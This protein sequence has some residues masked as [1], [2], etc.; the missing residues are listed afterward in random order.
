MGTLRTTAAKQK[1]FI[2]CAKSTGVSEEQI[3]EWYNDPATRSFLNAM[4]E[5]LSNK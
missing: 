5:A 4:V 1:D 2:D 3:K